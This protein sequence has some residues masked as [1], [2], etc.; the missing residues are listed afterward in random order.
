M[1]TEKEKELKKAAAVVSFL[2]VGSG[3]GYGYGGGAVVT[4]GDRSIQFG[5]GHEARKLAEE[6]VRRWNVGAEQQ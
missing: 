6:V 5:E 2:P 1:Q 3:D 4:I